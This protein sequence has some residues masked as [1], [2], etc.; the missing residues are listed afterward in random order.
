M[1]GI[2]MHLRYFYSDFSCPDGRERQQQ[3]VSWHPAEEG[4]TWGYYARRL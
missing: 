4:D 2:M 1:Q 3:E